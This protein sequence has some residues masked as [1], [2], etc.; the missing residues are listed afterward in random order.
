MSST[1][2]VATV[3]DGL[4][5][6]PLSCFDLPACAPPNPRTE[7][8]G[9]YACGRGAEKAAMMMIDLS[10]VATVSMAMSSKKIE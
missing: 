10:E 2:A 1:P 7:L 3:I 4:D 5:S 8:I 6:R 9:R